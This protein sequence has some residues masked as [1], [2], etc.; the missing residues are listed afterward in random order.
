MAKHFR[1]VGINSLIHYRFPLTAIVSILHRI[2]GLILFLFVPFLIW[3]LALSLRS[4]A[5]FQDLQICLQ[6]HGGIRFAIWV[7][8][9]ALSYHFV[10]GI[11]HFIMDLSYFESLPGGRRSS[12]VVILLSVI[13]VV[14]LGVWLW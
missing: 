1:N 4:E 12:V 7:F 10:A 2:S 3:V 8:L 11:R 14:V 5:S 13:L 9:S 6:Q